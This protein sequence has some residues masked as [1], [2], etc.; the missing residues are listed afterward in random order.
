MHA[1]LHKMD[2]HVVILLLMC[3]CLQRFLCSEQKVSKWAPRF[4]L[5]L[6]NP[7]SPTLSFSPYVQQ[8]RDIVDGNSDS[9]KNNNG[10]RHLDLALPDPINSIAQVLK[11]N[12][13]DVKKD[14]VLCYKTIANAKN[15]YE[16]VEKTI[17][18]MLTHKRSLA[19]G[20]IC[21]CGLY[22][23]IAVHPEK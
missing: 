9:M 19:I 18:V 6:F 14:L 23:K 3:F 5:K 20:I 17:D 16:R 1:L 12:A 15:S 13:E 22:S 4:G 8:K 21:A 7:A 2:L 11:R 10:R